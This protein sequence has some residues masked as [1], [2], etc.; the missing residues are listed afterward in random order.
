MCT[1]DLGPVDRNVY[2]NVGAFIDKDGISMYIYVYSQ[3]IIPEIPILISG[4]LFQ[5]AG[6]AAWKEMLV[7]VA[8]L[9][10]GSLQFLIFYNPSFM[11]KKWLIRFTSFYN[12]LCSCSLTTKM[13]L[14]VASLF[15]TKVDPDH[16][17]KIIN[18]CMTAR[19]LQENPTSF[20]SSIWTTTQRY[21]VIHLKQGQH[22]SIV[23]II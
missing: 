11:V 17:V 18:W 20:K 16:S 12:F 1:I 5:N 4:R 3:W 9:T 19:T 14:L 2:C 23:K 22:I 10:K 13:S 7:G 15:I 8:C 6:H 21:S